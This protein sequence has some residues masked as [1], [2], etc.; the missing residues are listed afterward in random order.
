MG[1][2]IFHNQKM[3]LYQYNKKLITHEYKYT[4]FILHTLSNSLSKHHMS[5]HT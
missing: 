2:D 5:L 3:I 4:L 1:I